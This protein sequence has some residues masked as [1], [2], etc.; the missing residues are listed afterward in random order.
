[1]VD[2]GVGADEA[3]MGF[4]DEDGMFADDA[5]GFAE[6]EFDEA[7]IFCV[8]SLSE[9]AA[10]SMARWD[11]VMVVRS[12]RRFSDLEIIFW[13]RTRMS[14]C[15]NTSLDFFA[16]ASRMRGRLSLGRISGMWEMGRSW[17]GRGLGMDDEFRRCCWRGRKRFHHRGHRVRRGARRREIR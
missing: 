11:G 5:A 1:M 7:R 3:V 9:A 14:F 12:M 15:W 8:R 16:A 17:I 4:D 13:A 6:D 10:R 2:A